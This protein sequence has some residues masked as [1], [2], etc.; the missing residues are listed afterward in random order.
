MCFDAI[1]MAIPAFVASGIGVWCQQ[2]WVFSGARSGCFLGVVAGGRSAT[3][4]CGQGKWGLV[5]LTDAHV[6]VHRPDLGAGP[7][8]TASEAGA[9]Q[10][11]GDKVPNP[12]QLRL[13]PH[14]SDP[15]PH[16]AEPEDWAACYG[17]S[18]GLR[19]QGDC[20]SGQGIP[21]AGGGEL[22]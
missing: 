4:S 16:Q 14:Q 22:S 17:W 21:A 6:P 5:H 20:G 19:Q 7:S 13:N 1:R 12:H 8:W 3:S 10:G 2:V 18:D 15:N 9:F 11:D